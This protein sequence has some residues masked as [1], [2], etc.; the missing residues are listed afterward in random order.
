MGDKELQGSQRPREIVYRACSK[1][2]A[3]I[4]MFIQP[5][6]SHVESCR[7]INVCLSHVKGQRSFYLNFSVC[8][9]SFDNR[10]FR[11]EKRHFCASSNDEM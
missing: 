2:N 4:R 7:H 9:P 6:K 8:T 1:T 10:F 5:I 11:V 3:F